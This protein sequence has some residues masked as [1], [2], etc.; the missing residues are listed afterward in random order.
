MKIGPTPESML[1]GVQGNRSGASPAAAAQ[2]RPNGGPAAHGGVAVSKSA[3]ALALQQ[4]DA[5]ADFDAAKVQAMREA[6]ANGSFRVN[7]EAIAD[8]LLA[9]AQEMLERA[10]RR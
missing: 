9:N 6:I 8:K 10:A 2:A 1:A 5:S 4:T 7:A 3:G